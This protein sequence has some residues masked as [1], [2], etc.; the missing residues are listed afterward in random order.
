MTFSEEDAMRESCYAA[1]LRLGLFENTEDTALAHEMGWN[2]A[3]TFLAMQDKNK[4]EA[5]N[6][7]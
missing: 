2:A 6:G 3:I 1:A 5:A 7:N 4:D